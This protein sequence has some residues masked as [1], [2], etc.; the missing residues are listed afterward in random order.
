MTQSGRCWP[1]PAAG[2]R[3]MTGLDLQGRSLDESGWR[4]GRGLSALPDEGN[5]RDSRL[6]SAVIV[7]ILGR[8]NRT[9]RYDRGRRPPSAE[10]KISTQVLETIQVLN[11]KPCAACVN[12]P[13]SVGKRCP[14][15]KH[16]NPAAWGFSR[17]SCYASASRWLTDWQRIEPLHPLQFRD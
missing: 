10:E 13:L 5:G 4:R 8:S 1:Q 2:D 11:K 16:A 14:T 6:L 17:Q 15:A 12:L 9:E 3:L 7:D